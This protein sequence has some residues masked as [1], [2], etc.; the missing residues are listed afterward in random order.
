M[1]RN[2]EIAM[3]ET[4]RVRLQLEA[5][6]PIAFGARRGTTSSFVDTLDYVP[7]T[8]LRGALAARFLR[9]F[10]NADDERFRKVF[11]EGEVLFANL[12]PLSDG[13]ISWVLPATAHACKAYKERHG[14]KDILIRAAALKLMKP[15]S[16]E[17]L[18]DEILFCSHCPQGWQAV[19]LLTGFY[20]KPLSRPAT[21]ATV[22]VHKR[23][24]THVGINRKKQSAEE[25]FLFAQQVINEARRDSDSRSFSPQLFSGELI[26]NK[27][28]AEFLT[29]E[30]LANGTDFRM[31][32]S[33]TRGLGRV[34]VRE[35]KVVNADTEDDVKARIVQFNRKFSERFS[36]DR[37]FISLT[38]QSDT[39]L[40]DEFMRPSSTLAASDLRRAV[41]DDP[42]AR[43]IT[44]NSLRPVYAN[45]G[46]RLV[47]TWNVTSGYPK[48]DDVAITMGSVF[49]FEVTEG[50]A[51]ELAAPLLILQ[52][53]GIGKRRIEGFGRVTVCDPFHLEVED[54]WRAI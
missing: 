31:G 11:L 21:Y 20:E 7:G 39:M 50:T 30:L 23:H 54:L 51:E 16:C 49:L 15:G 32:E 14:V 24:L 5:L 53:H 4:L 37:I 27:S 48:P 6:S 9:E 44:P 35:C 47:Q 12:Y 34:R 13:E 36:S 40:T 29:H 17:A 19:K 1:L 2:G 22:E 25:G 43:S 41:G 46:K 42:G 33:R 52:E 18:L 45:A 3:G 8:S 28:Q 10:A 38:L 26:A